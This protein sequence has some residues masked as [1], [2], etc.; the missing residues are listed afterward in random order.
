MAREKRGTPARIH[1]ADLRADLAEFGGVGGDREVAERREHVSAADRETIDAR[2]NGLGNVANYRLE[3]IDRQADDSA[4]VV[5]PL[6]R[7]LVAAGAE[8]LVPGASQHD[9]G[10]VF[11]VTGDLE[12][13]D[14]LFHRRC[15]ESVVELGT[16]DD[17]PGGAF[18]LLIEDVFENRDVA[19]VG[20][21]RIGNIF[22][23][24][25]PLR[26]SPE[27]VGVRVMHITT[28]LIRRF[29]L[30]SPQTGEGLF[31]RQSIFIPPATEMVWPVMKPASSDAR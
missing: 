15:A 28:S 25:P 9:R 20:S 31:R 19:H 4:P 16:I 26:L 1:R 2:D 7:A 17:D 27:R 21:F 13:L 8:R 30:R 5:L 6:V 18:A 23:E 24:I 14:Q 10:H 3:F 22:S 29:A 12:G 11:V